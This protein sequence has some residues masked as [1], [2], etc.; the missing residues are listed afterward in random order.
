MEIGIFFIVVGG[1]FFVVGAVTVWAFWEKL[2]G[3]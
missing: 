3:K 2:K 1:M